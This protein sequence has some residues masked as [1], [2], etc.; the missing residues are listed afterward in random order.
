MVHEDLETS[1]WM[2]NLGITLFAIPLVI[3]GPTGGRLAQ[4][5]G[6]FRVAA[7]GLGAAALFMFLYGQVPTGTWIFSIAMLHAI[8]D[9]VGLRSCVR[10]LV[11]L[12]LTETIVGAV[13]AL[14]RA[15]DLLSQLHQLLDSCR[16]LFPL[17]S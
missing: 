15:L 12:K 2:A 3:L 10:H 9:G 13:A 14:I 7:A 17:G 5:V 1:T 8:T 4:R 11:N 16:V 6:P